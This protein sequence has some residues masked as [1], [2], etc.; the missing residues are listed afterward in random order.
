MSY[1]KTLDFKFRFERDVE[2]DGKSIN[3]KITE[4]GTILAE[5]QN[6]ECVSDFVY[7]CVKDWLNNNHI[8]HKEFLMNRRNFIATVGVVTTYPSEP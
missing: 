8:P 1:P 4:D 5:Y 2:L 7:E 3:I 6:G